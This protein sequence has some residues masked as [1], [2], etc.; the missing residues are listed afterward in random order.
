MS[1]TLQ[2]APDCINRGVGNLARSRLSGGSLCYLQ[3]FPFGKFRL[4]AGCSQDWPMPR[5]FLQLD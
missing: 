4:K 3:A 5:T 2:I 1:P